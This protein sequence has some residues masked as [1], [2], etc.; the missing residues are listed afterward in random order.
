MKKLKM[1]IKKTLLVHLKRYK[2]QLVK[3]YETGDEE[4][5]KVRHILINS[6]EGDLDDA[7]IKS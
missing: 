5:A 6:K 1:V 7:K 2:I 4:Q 3:I